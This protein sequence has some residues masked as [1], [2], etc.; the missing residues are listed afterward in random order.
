MKRKWKRKKR[1]RVGVES[2]LT[3]RPMAV[4]RRRFGLT[5]I[6]LEYSH[7][8]LEPVKE[9]EEE[10]NRRTGQETQLVMLKR[11]FVLAFTSCLETCRL[12]T[13]LLAAGI[14]ASNLDGRL[15]NVLS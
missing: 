13:M 15:M 14:V 11:S 8:V 4:S 5:L 6:F 3:H 1:G 10:A 9:E 7:T 12:G 2:S